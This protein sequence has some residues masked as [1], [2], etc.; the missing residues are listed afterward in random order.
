MGLHISLAHLYVVLK[1]TTQV[2]Q[3]IIGQECAEGVQETPT[4]IV[5]GKQSPG[6]QV[7]ANL[8]ANLTQSQH[9]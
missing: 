3:L 6:Q 1:K 9:K 8:F 4:E 2:I 5:S 7:A